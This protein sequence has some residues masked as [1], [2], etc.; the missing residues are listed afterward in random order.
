MECL[1]FWNVCVNIRLFFCLFVRTSRKVPCS[2]RACGR[3]VSFYQLLRLI[4]VWRL[5][6]YQQLKEQSNKIFRIKERGGQRNGAYIFQ[7]VQK[8]FSFSFLYI[9]LAIIYVVFIPE[10]LSGPSNRMLHVS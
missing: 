7:R 9:T 4:S 1:C 2:E 10:F 6:R 8:K 5:K 3:L